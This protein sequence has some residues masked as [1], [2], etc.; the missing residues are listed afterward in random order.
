MSKQLILGALRCDRTEDW[1][2][3]DECRLEILSDTA[4]QVTLKRSMRRGQTWPLDQNFNF[5]KSI[6]VRLWDEDSPD[7]DDL[8]G[9]VVLGS[10]TASA[11]AT[12]TLDGADYTLSYRTTK[13][14]PER[15]PEPEPAPASK[16][17]TIKLLDVRCRDTE[18]V[19]GPDEFY[20][21]G[22]VRHSSTKPAKLVLVKPFSIND[23]QTK[24]LHNREG[25]IAFNGV[26][27]N[28]A[29]IVMELTAYDEDYGK[30][31]KSIASRLQESLS[32]S[33][34]E[35]A[36]SGAGEVGGA[37]IALGV[38]YA[39]DAIFKRDKDD[40]LGRMAI[41]IPAKY[42]RPGTQTRSWK[43][44]KGGPWWSNSKWNYTVRYQLIV[45]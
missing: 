20:I 5:E 41:S 3:G 27:E 38:F 44:S 35:A 26:V 40:Q 9:A 24:Q 42:L 6:T 32:K 34:L 31:W 11:T 16:K 28:D 8:L 23:N 30:D 43:F 22:S 25:G 2:G 37:T 18:D 12:F 19:S 33:T 36:G 17:I 7:P 21:V 39:M 29:V 14:L 10:P 1:W 45:D 13:S 15:E 4:P